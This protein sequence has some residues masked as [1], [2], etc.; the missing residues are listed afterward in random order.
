MAIQYRS[1]EPQL[2]AVRSNEGYSAWAPLAEVRNQIDRSKTDHD[3][4]LEVTCR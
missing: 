1:I 2:V 4:R 3:L